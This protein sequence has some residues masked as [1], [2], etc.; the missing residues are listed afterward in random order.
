MVSP[1]PTRIVVHVTSA[2][3][4][5]GGI[6]T[7]NRALLYALDELASQHGWS[8]QV[9]SLL[10]SA[11]IPGGESYGPSGF[12]EVR[13]FS[14]N[15]IQFARFACRASRSAD[16][17]I[18]G[19]ANFLPLAPLMNGSFKC[20]VAHGIEV[21]RELP[22]LQKLGTSHIN[23]ILC[24][25]GYTKREMMRLNGLAEDRFCVFPN[26]MDPLY[27]QRSQTKADRRTLGLPPGPMLLSVSRL[28]PSERSKNIRAVIKSLPAVLQQVPDAFYVLIGDGAERKVLRELADG[29]G[30]GAKV[31]LPGTV[32][33]KLLPSY[34]EA[35]DVFVLPSVREGFG[36]VFLE[37]MYHGKACIG[38]N[39]GGVPE[40]VQNGATGLLVDESDIPTLLSQ[41]ILRLLT[42]AA[43]CKTMGE[44]GR[45]ELE[46]N[47]TFAHFRSRLEQI[48]CGSGL[49]SSHAAL[50]GS[51]VL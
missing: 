40:V 46:S 43:L 47:F 49:S 24:V 12:S 7:F 42:D 19:H 30:L 28:V 14:A 8:V 35:C 15:R 37:A 16:I 23:R 34:Y 11:R 39:A 45:Q 26:T 33:D 27:A 3:G 44:Q 17:V 29:T 10:D 18:I 9:F 5:I 13:G 38:A 31:F 50:F 32:P 1:R 36:I 21:W 4:G 6:E 41:V 25:S 51:R 20:L 2:F 22:R 48:I